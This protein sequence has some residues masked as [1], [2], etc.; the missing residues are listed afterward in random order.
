MDYLH[1]LINFALRQRTFTY[2][3]HRAL[4]LRM[5]IDAQTFVYYGNL[6]YK[7]M[8][9]L[10]KLMLKQSDVHANAFATKI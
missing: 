4:V 3:Y 8:R 9:S 7:E 2:H 5:E 1:Q 10:F 6:C